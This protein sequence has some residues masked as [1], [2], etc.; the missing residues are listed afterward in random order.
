MSGSSTL[1]GPPLGL[2]TN[3]L[4]ADDQFH[5]PE[6]SPSISVTAKAG[7]NTHVYSRRSQSVSTR[8]EHVLSKINGG[9]AI[10]YGS[11]LA[12]AYAAHTLLRPRGIAIKGGY[13]GVHQVIQTFGRDRDIKVVDLDD[14]FEGID[15]CSVETPLN[16]TGEARNI[17][18]YADKIHS[19]GG[20]LVVDATFA[21]PPLQYPFKWGADII[22]HS[23]SRGHSD[24]LGGVLIVKTLGEWGKLQVDRVALG[25]VMGSL[26]S[27][28]LLR[29]LRTL[30]LRIPRQSANATA[31][32]QWLDNIA[33]TPKGQSFDGVIG[34]VIKKVWH[35]SL[36]KKDAS[37]WS[38]NQQMEGGHSPTFAILL[39]SPDIA[40]SLPLSLKYFIAATSLGGVESL[41]EQRVRSSPGEDPRVVRISV[42]VEDISHLKQ[43]LRSALQALSR[44]NALALNRLNV[45]LIFSIQKGTKL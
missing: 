10:T 40:S 2:A 3:L 19:C 20:R 31:L 9:Y 11:G 28:L 4:H 16:P 12:A 18:H 41:I 32:A 36:Q 13:H 24:L 30:H 23:V 34:G 1:K 39:E 8:V 45:A 43:D 7:S 21:P 22:M 37:G 33:S 44:V 26:E 42:G 6:V 38:P 29:S 35:S 14:D 15:V 25:G 27:W 17:R 5:G